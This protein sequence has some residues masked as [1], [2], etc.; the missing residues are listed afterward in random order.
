VQ[1][2]LSAE[3]RADFIHKLSISL[4]EARE[5]LYWIEQLGAGGYLQGKLYESLHQDSLSL[6]KL[7][8]T[9]IKT[10]KNNRKP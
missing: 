10:A 2:A 8:Y 6:V 3:S 4:K 9:A 5:T 7:L 1:E